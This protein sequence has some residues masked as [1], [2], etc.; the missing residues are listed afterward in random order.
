MLEGRV[1]PTNLTLLQEDAPAPLTAHLLS[2]HHDSLAQGLAVA[3]PNQ[4]VGCPSHE[5]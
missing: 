2:E 3:R 5:R 4:P 1:G